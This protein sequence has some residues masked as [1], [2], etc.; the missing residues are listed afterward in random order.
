[1]ATLNDPD[2]AELLEK[3]NYAVISTHNSDGSIHSAV[4][5]A[6]TEGETLTVNSALGRKW[7]TNLQRDPKATVL[8]YAQDNPYHY[9]EIRG[10]AQSSTDGADDHINRLTRKY[11]GQDE[12]PFRQP[13]EQRVKF[14]I[15]PSQVRVQKQ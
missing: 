5:W 4:V 6:D 3:P 11:L 12:Y 7:P 14:T 13:G 1:M 8:I 9:V 15:S 2:V 10:E